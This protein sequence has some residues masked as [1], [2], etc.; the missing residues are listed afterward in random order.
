MGTAVIP[1][2]LD[3]AQPAV[4]PRILVIDDNAVLA[5]SFARMLRSYE[6]WSNPIPAP[7]SR[8]SWV[9]SGST[10]SCVTSICRF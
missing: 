2:I 10:S 8:G 3:E 7:R 1:L 9:A 4:R 6:R 5:R